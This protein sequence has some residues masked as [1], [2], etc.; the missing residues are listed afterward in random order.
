MLLRGE[1]V[2]VLSITRYQSGFLAIF[3][4]EF[5]AVEA[6]DDCDEGYRPIG[7]VTRGNFTLEL[8]KI[9]NRRLATVEHGDVAKRSTDVVRREF[10]GVGWIGWGGQELALSGFPFEE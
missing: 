7:V 9:E 10:A 4:D 2:L 3:H 1:H 8:T 5:Q 6:R